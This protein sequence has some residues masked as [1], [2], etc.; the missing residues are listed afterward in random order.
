MYKNEDLVFDPE[1]PLQVLKRGT[2]EQWV[3][4]KG[5]KR[6]FGAYSARLPGGRAG[7]FRAFAGSSNRR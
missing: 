6:R 2:Y 7:N 4:V 5:K 1:H 3:N